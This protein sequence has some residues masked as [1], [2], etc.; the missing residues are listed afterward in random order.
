MSKGVN[1]GNVETMEKINYEDMQTVL[2]HPETYLIINTMP[3]LE[4]QCLILNT[5]KAE[6]E[7]IAIN[8]Y[9]KDNKKIRIVIY[10]K[11]CNDEHIHKKNQQLL[12]LGFQNIFVYMGGIFEWLLLQD[13]YGNE[14]FPTT[15]KENDLLKYKPKQLFNISLIEY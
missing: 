3:I 14:L 15:N 11:N 13:I 1:M 4:Q 5:I 8:K 2:K 6:D 9:I 12:S 7:E 10:G